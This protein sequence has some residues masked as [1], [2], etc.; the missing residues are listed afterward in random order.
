MKLPPVRGVSRSC[1]GSVVERTSRIEIYTK[2]TLPQGLLSESS[3]RNLSASIQS[4]PGL[5]HPD[6]TELCESFSTGLAVIAVDRDAGNKPVG[7]MRMESL[8]SESVREQLGLPSDFPNVMELGTMFT[9]N[10]DK[11]RGKGLMSQLSQQLFD[12]YRG[13]IESGNVLVIGTT[14]DWRVIRVLQGLGGQVGDQ[15]RVLNHLQFP[16]VAA[17]TCICSGDFGSGFQVGPDACTKRID[18][19]TTDLSLDLGGS[20]ESMLSDLVSE[21]DS[22]KIPC[23]MFV[24]SVTAARNADTL[25]RTCGPTD[26]SHDS[27]LSLRNRLMQLGYYPGCSASS[28]QNRQVI[29]IQDLLASAGVHGRA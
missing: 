13:D 6:G 21:S 8:L 24:S 10:D 5:L 20:L 23:V 29:P 14:K 18:R 4:E 7:Y 22:P 28:S 11:Y 9:L 2:D 12:H 17:L 3:F 26:S 1:G 27:V 16:H 25:L 19:S 15:F